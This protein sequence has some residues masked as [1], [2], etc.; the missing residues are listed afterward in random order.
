MI[1]RHKFTLLILLLFYHYYTN[2]IISKFEY[3]FLPIS[4]QGP[5]PL[6]P[7]KRSLNPKRVKLHSPP[8]IGTEVDDLIFKEK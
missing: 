5:L 6:F 3:I 7:K 8:E 1:N 4:K 2:E